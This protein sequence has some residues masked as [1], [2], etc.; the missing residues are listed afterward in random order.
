LKKA[1]QTLLLDERN[2]SYKHGVVF[3]GTTQ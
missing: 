3:R 2:Q 1:G